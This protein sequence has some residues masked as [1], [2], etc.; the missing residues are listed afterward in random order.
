[1][2]ASPSDGASVNSVISIIV[3]YD[4]EVV[5]LLAFVADGVP[6]GDLDGLIAEIE[7]LVLLL[8]ALKTTSQSG[9]LVD[10]LSR[11]RPMRRS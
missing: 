9:I 8:D 5:A 2:L 7:E 6:D 1:M 4:G 3:F 10:I 11:G